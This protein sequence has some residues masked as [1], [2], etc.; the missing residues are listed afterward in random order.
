MTEL[1]AHYTKAGAVITDSIICRE[2]ESMTAARLLSHHMA[3]EHPDY[4]RMQRREVDETKP[5][6]CVFCG[7]EAG[8]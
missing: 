2:C 8:E 5:Y 1:R 7:A 3:S 6:S 4:D